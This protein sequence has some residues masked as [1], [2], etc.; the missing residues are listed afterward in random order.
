MRSQ[1][2]S[3]NNNL[4]IVWLSSTIFIAIGQ[5]AIAV[6]I[7]YTPSEG[8]R[9]IDYFEWLDMPLNL[10]LQ[11]TFVAL[12]FAIVMTWVYFI[13]YHANPVFIDYVTCIVITILGFGLFF[14]LRYI[15]HLVLLSRLRTT[16]LQ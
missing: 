10:L 1:S 8:D 2:L 5:I 16:M 11:T 14:L 13:A 6:I 4:H 12:L 3:A 7:S 15:M 9:A